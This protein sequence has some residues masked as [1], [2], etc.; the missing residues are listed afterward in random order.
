MSEMV[1]RVARA[2]LKQRY[3][4]DKAPPDPDEIILETKLPWWCACMGEAM[5][6]IAAMRE[7]TDA[8]VEAGMDV[9]D[10]PICNGEVQVRYQAMI[11]AVLK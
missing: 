5:A 1:E 2:I 9:T 7:P 4:F 8:M 10:W 6:A 11:D 3:A